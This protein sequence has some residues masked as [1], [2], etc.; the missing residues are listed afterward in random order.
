[1]NEEEKEYVKRV[2]RIQ[3]AKDLETFAYDSRR[4]NTN[5]FSNNI[6]ESKYR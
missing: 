5:A 3:S 2:T 1:M 6:N 4:K